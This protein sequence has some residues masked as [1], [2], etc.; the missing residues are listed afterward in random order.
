M[1][2]SSVNEERTSISRDGLELLFSSNRM[3]PTTNEAIFVSTRAS[4]SAAWNPPVPVT[5][6]NTIGSN[7]Q[8][9]LSADG[10]TVF[11]VSNRTGGFGLGDIYMSVRVSINRTPTGDFDGDGRTDLSVYRPS[12]GNWYIQGTTNIYTIVGWGGVPDDVPVA[13]DFDGDGRNDFAI[14]RS[15]EWYILRSSDGTVSVTGWG[16]GGD[17]PTPGDFDGD[18]RTDLAV[19]RDDTWY[20]IQSSNGHYWIRQFGASGD[21]PIISAPAN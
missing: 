20:I 9:F 3:V 17:V 7:A 8:P 1:L 15:G 13:G 19:Y 11:T 10:T 4:T 2:N 21:T 16:A 18:G 5:T 12:N 14:F 6:L